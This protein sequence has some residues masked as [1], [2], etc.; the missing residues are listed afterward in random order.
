MPG[1]R[2]TLSLDS[3][4]SWIGKLFHRRGLAKQ[5]ACF[6]IVQSLVLGTWRRRLPVALKVHLED[7]VIYIYL[8]G[9]RGRSI[10]AFIGEH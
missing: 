1:F 9:G 3:V 4:L 6:P 7:C 8:K 2:A 5:E 10:E